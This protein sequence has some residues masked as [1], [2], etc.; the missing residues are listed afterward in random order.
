[1]ATPSICLQNGPWK[2]KYVPDVAN[3]KYFLNS[4]IVMFKPGLS[5]NNKITVISIVSLSGIY[6]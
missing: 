2:E 6:Y 4:A 1:M 3:S 5:S